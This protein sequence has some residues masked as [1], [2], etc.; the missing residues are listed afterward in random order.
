MTDTRALKQALSAALTPRFL[1]HAA[2]LEAA[3]EDWNQSPVLGVDTEFLRERT[4]RA[5][6]GLVQVSN[7]QQAWLIDPLKLESLD[8]LKRMLTNPAIVKVLHSSSED[9]EVLWHSLGVVPSPL[10]DTQIACAMLGQPLQMSYHHVVK[11]LYDIEVDKDQT[12]SNWLRR[13]L[14]DEQLHYAA[15]DVV[16]LPMMLIRLRQELRDGDRWHWIEEDVERMVRQ[17]QVATNPDTAYQR[18]S[19]AGRLDPVSLATLATLAAWREQ[20][21]AK[22]NIARGFVVSDAALMKLAQKRP[23]TGTQL[24]EIEDIHPGTRRKY[25]DVLLRLIEAAGHSGQPAE[26]IVGLDRQQL[27]LLNRMRDKVKEQ[28]ETLGIDPAL[29]ASRKFLEELIKSAAAGGEPP[30]RLTGWRYQVITEQLLQLASD[31]PTG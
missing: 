10:I 4:Y 14:S 17:C 25:Q 9:L 12:R 15:S 1:Q 7:G 22:K 20:V 29:L 5:E 18:I 21:A 19:G 3:E 16:F 2:D 27:Q 30:E 31:G 13:P 6:L 23:R 26:P 8:A 28:A 11:W 24:A